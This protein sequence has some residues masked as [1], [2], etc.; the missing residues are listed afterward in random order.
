MHCAN[1]VVDYG[2]PFS[3]PGGRC[4]CLAVLK[5]LNFKSTEMA[6]LKKSLDALT[7][8]IERGNL[9][10]WDKHDCA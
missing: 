1:A 6:K 7:L 8:N 10:P 9:K 2:Y 5:G 4:T 3:G